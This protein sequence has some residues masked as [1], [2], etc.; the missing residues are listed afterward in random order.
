MYLWREVPTELFKRVAEVVPIPY[1]IS[2]R[3]A[4]HASL[5]AF[6]VE[7]T[8]GTLSQADALGGRLTVN[9]NQRKA[10]G[11]QEQMRQG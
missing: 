10:D 7:G 3:A 9:D 2:R 1:G 4:G 11:D 8:V 5:D 6:S